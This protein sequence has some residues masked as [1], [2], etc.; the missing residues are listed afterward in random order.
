[1][2]STRSLSSHLL[3]VSRL[4]RFKGFK[5]FMARTALNGTPMTELLRDVTSPNMWDHT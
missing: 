2:K 4:S 5:K 3:S 1:M